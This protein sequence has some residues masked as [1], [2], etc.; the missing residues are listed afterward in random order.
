MPETTGGTLQS[1]VLIWPICP[2]VILSPMQASS[3]CQTQPHIPPYPSLSGPRVI[4]ET[5]HQPPSS[6]PKLGA[7]LPWKKT[8]PIQHPP[9]LWVIPLS[10]QEWVL[11]IQGCRAF[12]VSMPQVFLSLLS[13]SRALQLA[14]S[15]MPNKSYTAFPSSTG[16]AWCHNPIREMQCTVYR[17]WSPLRTE[18]L[19]EPLPWGP[20]SH[21]TQP[22]CQ[23]PW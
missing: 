21:P 3:T 15:T 19:A 2:S 8:H 5:D 22:D 9:S 17:E 18:E 14:V 20:K 10:L 16:Y 11:E 12:R 13:I 4:E 23:E 6:H 1:S 7:S